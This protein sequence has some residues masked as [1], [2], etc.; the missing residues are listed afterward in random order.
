MNW[1]LM[2]ASGVIS[3]SL[4]T[5]A[6]TTN[7][8]TGEQQASRTAIGAGIGA[9]SGAIIGQVIGHNATSTLVG[10]AIGSAVGG[11]AGNMLD[12]QAAEL[13]AQLQGTGVSVT[14]VGDQV[15][16]NM[17]SDITFA[18]NSADIKSQ[19]YPV[20]NSVA[21]VLKKYHNKAIEVAGYTDSTGNANYNQKLSHQRA[22][23]VAGYL[24]SQ[25][26]AGNRFAVV[27]YGESNPVASNDTAQ[28]RAQNRRVEIILH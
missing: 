20:L 21:L 17:P 5:A 15:R 9:A 11:V 6:C 22:R 19:F 12:R 16:L 1:R 7:P 26:V 25:G 24:S 27:G 10:A 3:L 4:I 14:K 18:L 28:G 13:R 23:S 8:Y 2:T